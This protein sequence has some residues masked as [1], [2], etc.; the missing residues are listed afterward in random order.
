MT[1]EDR[2]VRFDAAA[3]LQDEETLRAY[4]RA[5]LDDPAPGALLLA[6]ENVNRAIQEGWVK[7]DA[8]R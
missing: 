1:R 7:F 4:L 8:P 6:L 5:A 3:Y 2:N